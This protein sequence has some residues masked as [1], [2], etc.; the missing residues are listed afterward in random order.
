[1]PRDKSTAA[2]NDGTLLLQRQLDNVAGNT[3]HDAAASSQH[4][5]KLHRKLAARKQKIVDEQRHLIIVDS[6]EKNKLGVR[7]KRSNQKRAESTLN[8]P[9]VLAQDELN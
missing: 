7:N 8:L 6:P 3:Q 4:R 9:D 5:K 1:M 2:N